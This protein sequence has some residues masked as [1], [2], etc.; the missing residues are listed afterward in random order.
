MLYHYYS[1]LYKEQITESVMIEVF[2]TMFKL[3]LAIIMPIM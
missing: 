1:Q 2:H 3:P